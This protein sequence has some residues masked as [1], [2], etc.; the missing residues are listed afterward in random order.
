MFKIKI[1]KNLKDD[2]LSYEYAKEIVMNRTYKE[3]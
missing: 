3:W 1:N 2:K